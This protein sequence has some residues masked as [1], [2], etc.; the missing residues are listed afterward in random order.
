MRR[1]VLSFESR[2]AWF[3]PGS[4]RFLVP[5]LQNQK[6]ETR[7]FQTRKSKLR[8]HAFTLPEPVLSVSRR[9]HHSMTRRRMFPSKRE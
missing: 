3:E 9:A 5:G 7:N 6:L 2:V 4:R 1:E 8:E